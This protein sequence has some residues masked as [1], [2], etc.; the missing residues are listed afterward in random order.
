MFRTVQSFIWFV[1]YFFV[2]GMNN[3]IIY[4]VYIINKHSE[5]LGSTGCGR[6]YSGTLSS[7]RGAARMRYQV[8]PLL[9]TSQHVARTWA[10][11][12]LRLYEARPSVGH[13][14]TSISCTPALFSVKVRRVGRKTNTDLACW[15][16]N[17]VVSLV[18]LFF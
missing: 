6:T 3:I 17:S 12:L 7:L 8:S 16:L 15:W 5:Q 14:R 1:R 11:R 2:Y 10:C 13:S 9:M 4:I 18:I